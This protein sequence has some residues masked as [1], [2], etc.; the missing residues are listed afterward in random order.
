M[1][2]V[3][4]VVRGDSLTTVARQLYLLVFKH[5]S[6]PHLVGASSSDVDRVVTKPVL[7]VVEIPTS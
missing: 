5:G 3:Q 2:A 4:R 7:R 1:V 6:F